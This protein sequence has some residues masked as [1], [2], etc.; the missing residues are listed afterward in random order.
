MKWEGILKRVL[1]AIR[2]AKYHQ[3]VK[4]IKHVLKE[5]GGAV[6]MQGFIDAGNKL[7]GFEEKYL[8]YV[9]SDI[10][11]HDNWMAQHEHGDY[12]LKED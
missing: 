6:G 8:E 9:I 11:D 4:F 12:Y 2:N 10:L 3:Y 5:E 1:P 7:K